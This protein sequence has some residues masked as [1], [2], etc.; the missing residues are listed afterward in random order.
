MD[1]KLL[2]L[3][4]GSMLF[5]ACGN[6]A[7]EVSVV[8]NDAKMVLQDNAH[9]QPAVVEI[10]SLLG[11]SQVS[12]RV[13][14]FVETLA[15][16]FTRKR[17]QERWDL[18]DNV[19]EVVKNKVLDKFEQLG[20]LQTVVPTGKSYDYIVVLGGALIS[21]RK[22]FAYVKQ[23]WEQGV[24]A[25]SIVFLTSLRP[26]EQFEDAAALNDRQQTI[27]PIKESWQ[28]PAHNPVDEF[29][30]MQE[31]WRQAEL[32]AELAALPCEVVDTPQKTWPDGTVHRANTGDTM[33]CWLNK[34]PKPGRCLFISNQPYVGYQSA[35]IRRW[36][37]ANFSVETVGPD[38]PRDKQKVSVLIDSL[39][40]WLAFEAFHC[41][42]WDEKTLEAYL[43][44]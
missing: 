41:K 12:T 9:V 30:L 27:L 36:M 17:D 25:T 1:R 37:P 21:M 8:H 11:C 5:G 14:Q 10:M 13:D 33:E 28:P 35:V 4:L 43:K 22:R 24:R 19:D 38:A 6:G 39:F 40:R 3:F 32:P 15:P 42:L 23:I 18:H 31:L 16:R 34:K 20:L 7:Q 44:Q 26:L 2:S 29:G